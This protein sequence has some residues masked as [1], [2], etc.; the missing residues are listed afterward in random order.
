MLDLFINSHGLIPQALMAQLTAQGRQCHVMTLA[1]CGVPPVD[2]SSAAVEPLPAQNTPDVA[3]FFA[4]QTEAGMHYQNIYLDLTSC[5]DEL[6]EFATDA[7]AASARIERRLVEV[8]KVLKYGSQHFA[9]AE[10]GRIWV[11]CYDHSV[12]YSVN[13]PSN[14]ITNNAVI[15][16]VQSIA[17]EVAR[18][19][20]HVNVFLIHPPRESLTEAQWRAAKPQL[21][22]YGMKYKPQSLQAITEL[23]GMYAGL[24]QLSTTGAVIPVGSGIGSVNI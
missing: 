11:L 14:P 2:A 20:I 4:A 16:A 10:G 13:S 1:E 24:Q 18:L 8:L 22:V 6:Q 5:F 19:G 7:I 9:R 12:S 3:A 23:V 17:K 15:A 21:K